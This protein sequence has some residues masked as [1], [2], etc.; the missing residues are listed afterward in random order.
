MKLMWLMGNK[1]LKTFKTC[2]LHVVFVVIVVSYAL[3]IV[4]NN[5]IL[6]E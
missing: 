6:D 1:S 3:S 4:F 2:Q 5:R